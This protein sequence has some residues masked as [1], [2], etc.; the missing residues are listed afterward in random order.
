MFNQPQTSEFVTGNCPHKPACVVG[1]SLL[2]IFFS[3]V[4]YK[5][6]GG[7]MISFLKAGTRVVLALVDAV[8]KKQPKFKMLRVCDG[9]G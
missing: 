3:H 2:T 1:R 5:H 4:L 8:E 9:Q 7:E 6:F